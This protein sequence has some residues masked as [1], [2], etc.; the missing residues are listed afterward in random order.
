MSDA[1]AAAVEGSVRG[2]R[3]RIEIDFCGG[4]VACHNGRWFSF[5][6]EITEVWV[7]TYTMLPLYDTYIL[8][9]Y[10]YCNIILR[11]DAAVMSA[12]IQARGLIS[13]R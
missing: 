7:P 12:H 13:L 10:V 11:D 3:H 6:P 9:V 2:P 5:N 4:G 1:A 8:C